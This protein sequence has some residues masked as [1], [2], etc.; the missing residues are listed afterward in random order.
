MSEQGAERFVASPPPQATSAS[1]SRPRTDHIIGTLYM[2]PDSA[3]IPV[4]RSKL[5]IRDRAEFG[6]LVSRSRLLRP[7]EPPS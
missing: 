1:D 5:E 4:T 7:G 2:S 6:A 3:E